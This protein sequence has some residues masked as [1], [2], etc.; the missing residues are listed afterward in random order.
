M[1]LTI[2]TCQIPITADVE[3]N[4]RLILKEIE[5]AAMNG[6]KVAHFAEGA[7]SGYPGID[8]AGFAGFDWNKLRSCTKR[9]MES[10]RRMKIWVVLGSFHELSGSNKPHNCLYIIN[11]KGDIAERY[12]KM[13]CTG[14]AS[15]DRAD[16]KHLSPGSHFCIFK[17]GGVLCGTL[18]C[19]D[20]RYPEL[21]REYYKLGARVVFHSFYNILDK[22]PSKPEDSWEYIVRPTLQGYAANN[23][24]WISA[25]NTSRNYSSWGSFFVR[26]DGLVVNNLRRNQ[27]GLLIN[28]IDTAEKFS[29]AS[30]H[31]RDRC[32]QGIY[33][34]G[35][36]AG[37]LRSDD[38]TTL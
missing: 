13:F 16:L 14:N 5:N 19:H 10:A 38:R 28:V 9:I 33:H 24:M 36:L 37:D 35:V 7:L 12:D 4:C 25:N 3:K 18:I 20:F 23:Y 29:D 22:A 8:F 6:A 31:W 27:S 32:I 1:K 2:A 15:M 11:S 34:S 30:V 17:I 21:Y 26:P